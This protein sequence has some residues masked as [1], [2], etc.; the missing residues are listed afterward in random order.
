MKKVIIVGGGAAGLMAGI[1]AAR[2]GASVTILEHNEKP[3]KKILAT[4]NGR[5]NLTN[6][7]QRQDCYRSFEPEKV[8]QYLQKYSVADTLKFFSEIGIYTRNKNGWMYPNS[9][10]AQSVLDCLLME[11]SFRKV[12]I[13]TR[14]NISNIYFDEYGWNVSTDSWTYQGDAVILACGSPASQ[15]EGAS[16][17]GLHFADRYGLKTAAFEPALVGLR[18]AGNYFSSWAGVRVQASVTLVLQGVPLKTETGEV[19]L[20]DY[21]VSGIPVFQISRYAVRALKE[22][23]ET[24]I[25]LDFLPGFTEEELCAHL[26]SRIKNCPYKTMEEQLTGLLPA[27]L[28][29]LVTTHTDSISKVAKAIKSHVCKV[30]GASSFAQAQVCSGGILLQN[31]DENLQSTQYPGLYFAGEVLDVDGA[32]GGYNLQWAWSSGAIAGRAAANPL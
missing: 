27:K 32:C 8:W 22:N 29:P 31:L 9:E 16:D 2:E 15:V 12:K 5:C 4:G 14:Q 20:T 3:G 26:A 21:G 24:L 17:Y 7:N 30:K 10:Q 1:T 23:T 6:I 28:I 25:F 11:A 13:K 19:Q 18:L